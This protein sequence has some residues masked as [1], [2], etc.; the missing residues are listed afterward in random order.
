MTQLTD[1][2][3]YP[4]ISPITTGLKGKCPRCG[5]GELFAG[6]L[7]VADRCRNC[8]LS[9]AFADA[10]D[11]AAWFVILISGSVAVAAA[12]FLEFNWQPS[13]WVHAAGA[14]GFAVVLPLL[15][16][17]PVKGMLLCLQYRTK[18]EEGR[19]SS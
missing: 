1:E 17:R 10:G 3:Y 15:L 2:P 14:L 11:G 8:G 6:Y 16:L 18:A 7:T 19:L 12:F 13:Y 9:F 5:Q 4:A